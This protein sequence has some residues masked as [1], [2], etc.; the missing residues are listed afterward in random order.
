MPELP[1][2]LTL[3]HRGVRAVVGHKKA[4]SRGGSVMNSE[5]LKVECIL[6]I[7]PLL[8]QQVI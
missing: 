8:F 1:P 5:K 3:F 6:H 2:K 4:S 7:L